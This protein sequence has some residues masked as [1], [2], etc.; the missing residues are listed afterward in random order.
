[1]NVASKHQTSRPHK[2]KDWNEKDSESVSG[3]KH[4]Q[5]TPLLCGNVAKLF[6][7]TNYKPE[8]CICSL[9]EG[10]QKWSAFQMWQVNLDAATG[11]LTD[12]TSWPEFHNGVAAGLRLAPGQVGL[13]I[14]I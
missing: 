10:D 3:S 9:L 5:A 1:M 6:T 2:R 13:K 8:S 11:N 12:V 7:W 4:K 14:M